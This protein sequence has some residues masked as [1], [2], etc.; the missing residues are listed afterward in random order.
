V[1]EDGATHVHENRSCMKIRMDN[2]V[3][4]LQEAS[5]IV[6]RSHRKEVPTGRVGY[7]YQFNTTGI[8]GSSGK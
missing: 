1:D 5:M 8:D 6:R 2:F 4:T 3:A 7:Q